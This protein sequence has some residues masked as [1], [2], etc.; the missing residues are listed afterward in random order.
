M[1]ARCTG[2]P[3]N[4]SGKPSHFHR[5]SGAHRSRRPASTSTA[6]VEDLSSQ[7]DKTT[8]QITNPHFTTA[9]AKSA[10]VLRWMP[11][12][13]RQLSQASLGGIVKARKGRNSVRLPFLG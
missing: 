8:P 11:C 12:H 2:L 4:L 10:S 9:S 5:M 1:A 3:T 13:T 7:K 6:F